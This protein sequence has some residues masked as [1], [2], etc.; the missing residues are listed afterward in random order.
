MSSFM[1]NLYDKIQQNSAKRHRTVSLLMVMSIFVTSG[2]VWV[3]RG[4]GITMVNDPICDVE[5]HEHSADCIR[6]TLTCMVE[7]ETHIH[8]DACYLTEV[9]CPKPEHIHIPACYTDELLDGYIVQEDPEPEKYIELES[10]EVSDAEE[11]SSEDVESEES[12]LPDPEQADSNDKDENESD[13][14]ENSDDKNDIEQ[15]DDDATASGDSEASEE[16]A[17]GPLL[18]HG[19]NYLQSAE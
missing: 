5:E 15:T 17:E 11:P 9:I 14:D 7:D 3:L 12:G 2:V 1:D 6:Q 16:D 8:E 18:E 10:A 13:A 4:T 19:T